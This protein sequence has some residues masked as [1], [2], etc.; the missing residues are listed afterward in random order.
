[1]PFVGRPTSR[2]PKTEDAFSSFDEAIGG[3]ELSAPWATDR[4]YL[5]DIE[6]L[7]ELL[8]IP[9]KEG[10]AQASG[11]VAKAIDAWCAYELRR[12]GFEPDEV[13]P[14][15]TAPRVLPRDVAMLLEALP[16]QL[17]GAVMEQVLR[18][19]KVAPVDADVLGRVFVK[20]VDVL[21]AQWSRGAELLVS[22]K[23]MLSSFGNNLKNRFEES[24]G[25]AKNLRGRFPLV[26]L[27]F[28]FLVRSTIPPGDLEFAFDML[29]KLR[30]EDDVY[31][32]TCLLVAEWSD[33]NF[34]GV[35]LLVENVP[36]DLR[37]AQFLE[38][39]IARVLERTPVQFHV[40]V[41][42]LR[43]KRQLPLAEAEPDLTKDVRPDEANG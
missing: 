36:A 13:W 42:E 5:P 32:A 41:R 28:L 7:G 27:G 19:P 14:R 3:R 9:V 39:L 34:S 4:R 29:R 38:V 12:A 16:R 1:M 30:E 33:E 43:E 24:Y 22:T 2:V 25:D 20:Q 21:V 8:A 26:S 35:R 31:D 6:F 10:R 15:G 40:R 11:R 37:P 23:S 18:T 17:R